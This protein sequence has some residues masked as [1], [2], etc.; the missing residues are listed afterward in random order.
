MMPSQVC[1]FCRHP[2]H[3]TFIDLGTSPLSNSYLS[4]EDLQ[5]K[6]IFHLLHAKI[7]REC[8]LVQ[9]PELE[10]PEK[11]FSNYAY[12]SSYSDSWLKHSEDYTKNMIQ[13]FSINNHWSVIEIASNDGYLLQ[14]FKER[15]IP[16]LGIE[17]ANNV[18]D[19]AR[20]KEIP[21]ESVF[22]SKEV[23]EKMRANGQRADLLIANNVLAHVPNLNDFIAGL[24][25]LLAPSGILTI[26][27]P[28]LL[29][30]IEENQ[31]DTIYHEHFSYFSFLTAQKIFEK[32]NLTL[33][34]VEEIAVHGGSLR[35]YVKHTENT[36]QAITPQIAQLISQEKEFGL[37]KLQTYQQFSK[38]VSQLKNELLEFITQAKKSGKTIAGYGAPAKGNTLLNYCGISSD[39]ISFTVDRSPHKQGHYLPGTHIPIFHPDKIKEIKPDYLLILPWNIKDEII[40]QMAYI[41]N[42]H[43]KFVLPIPTLQVI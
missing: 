43:G 41:K 32:H 12:F 39:Y 17:P 9:L 23:A 8:F 11:I 33:F 40:E 25:I 27:F 36:D 31:F 16:I 35:I 18:A 28:H 37:D 42:W 4:Q 38:N 10:S 14:Y 1:R 20:A 29:R 21:T 13:R 7:C 26:E 34:D 6:E 3:E 5:E 2:L 19:V 22:F 30:L 15:H 24:K